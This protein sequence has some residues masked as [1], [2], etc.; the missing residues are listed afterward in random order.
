MIITC[1]KIRRSNW[2]GICIKGINRAVFGLGRFKF[3]VPLNVL[4]ACVVVA[5]KRG[6]SQ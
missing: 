4:L 1:I 3:T 2:V 6:R 5:R